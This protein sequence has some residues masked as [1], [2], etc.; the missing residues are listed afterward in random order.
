MNVELIGIYK[1]FG[2]VIANDDIHLNVPAGTIQG[3]LGENGAGKSTLMKILSGFFQADRGEIRLDGKPVRISSPADAIRNGIGMLHQDPLDFPPMKVIDDFLVGKDGGLFPNRSQVI[4]GLNHLQSQFDFSLDPNAYVDTLTVG[5]RQQLEILRLLWLGVKVLILDEPTTGISA[6]Q[7]EKLFTALRVLAEQG[8]AIIFVSHKL[9]DIEQLCNRVA[10]L[11]EGKLV[12]EMVPPYDIEQLVKLMFG[13]LVSLG[14]RESIEVSD[15]IMELKGVVIEDDRLQ[16]NVPDL[17]ICGGEVIGLAGMEGSGQRQFLRA[18]GGLI[19]PVA[20]KIMIQQ[21]DLTGKNFLNFIHQGVAYLPASRME[22]GLV[23]GLTLRD[24]FI[25][26][27]DQKGFFI[28][29]T[30]SQTLAEERIVEYN[31][32]GTP[33]SFVE[34]LSGGNQQRALLALLKNPLSLI[35]MEHPT[36]GL[37]VESA[38]YIWSKLKER[39]RQCSAILFISAD[40]DEILQ[41]SDRILVFYAGRVSQP[42]DAASTTIDQLGQLIGGKGW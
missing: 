28:D 22:E 25:L 21:Q 31:I 32:R 24:H 15:L 26:S 6:L 14:R 40:L 17:K 19:H 11:R 41:Y 38:I 16:I 4:Q 35:L 29:Q 30:S 2:E 7:K 33:D 27:G 23:T 34:D 36:R 8:K 20:G 12:G 39:C 42:L 5:E 18:C 37:D 13:K 3:I 10:V 9:E 1:A